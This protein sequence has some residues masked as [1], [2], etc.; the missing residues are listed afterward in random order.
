MIERKLYSRNEIDH[1]KKSIE[2]YK[3]FYLKSNR[4]PFYYL[5]ISIIVYI[6]SIY[7]LKKSKYFLPL[8]SFLTIRLFIIFHDCCHNNFFKVTEK[9]HN[10]G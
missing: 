10:S 9:Q 7:A 6:A 4:K 8:F 5:I 3:N 1:I 2:P